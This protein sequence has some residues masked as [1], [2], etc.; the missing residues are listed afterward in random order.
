MEGIAPTAELYSVENPRVVVVPPPDRGGR[1]RIEFESGPHAP[2]FRSAAW[3]C[4]HRAP[5]ALLWLIFV[6]GGEEARR[7]ISDFI[8][9][10][11]EPGRYQRA[12]GWAQA[13]AP[14]SSGLS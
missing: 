13:L 4:R 11:C 12:R 5:H 7:E 1:Y 9:S 3:R 10:R 6:E 8:C 2:G 14:S